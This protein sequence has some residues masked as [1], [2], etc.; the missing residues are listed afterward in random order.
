[1]EGRL[2]LE[3]R[4]DVESQL[5]GENIEMDLQLGEWMSAT[6]NHEKLG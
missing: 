5:A 6:R 3:I 2:E 1:M 4:G